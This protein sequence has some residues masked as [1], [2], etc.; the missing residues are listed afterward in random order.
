MRAAIENAAVERWESAV[1]DL[2][3]R[4]DEFDREGGVVAM[5]ALAEACP[6][7]DGRAAFELAGM[8]DSMG[9]EAEAGAE[10]DNGAR[11]AI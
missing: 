11:S 6:A 10:S 2:W 5:R 1:E 3:E 9:F 8:Y 7:A 4:C